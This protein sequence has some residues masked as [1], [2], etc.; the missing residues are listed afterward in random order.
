MTSETR[1]NKLVEDFTKAI[2]VSTDPGAAED[3]DHFIPDG[4]SW[5]V[6]GAHYCVKGPWSRHWPAEVKGVCGALSY[7]DGSL[8]V[9]VARGHREFYTWRSSDGA[10]FK[11]IFIG[12]GGDLHSEGG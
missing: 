1:F 4:W 12:F 7:P 6:E 8:L 5:T 9:R 11:V 2:D 3:I 10:G